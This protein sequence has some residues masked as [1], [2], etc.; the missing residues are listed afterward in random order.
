MAQ[1]LAGDAF[2]RDP[3]YD[4]CCQLLL[5]IHVRVRLP[6]LGHNYVQT[7]PFLFAVRNDLDRT[8]SNDRSSFRSPVTRFGVRCDNSRTLDFEADP[9]VSAKNVDLAARRDGVDVQ[10]TIPVA[11]IYGDDVGLSVVN[12]REAANG[13][14]RENVVDDLAVCDLFVF[15]AHRLWMFLSTFKGLPGGR[16]RTGCARCRRAAARRH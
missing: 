16:R 11:I 2:N 7:T 1:L 4:D 6:V 14:G 10:G 3:Q 9:S 15:S 8:I 5:I 12:H 13:R